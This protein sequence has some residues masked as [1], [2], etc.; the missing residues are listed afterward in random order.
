MSKTL[1]KNIGR[2][3]TPVGSYSHRGNKQGENLRIDNTWIL[4]EDDIIKAIGKDNVIP[5]DIGEIDKEIDAIDSLVTPG[6]VDGHTHL[7]FHGFRQNEIV[8]KLKGASYLEILKAGGGILDTVKNTRKASFDDLYKQADEAVTEILYSGVTTMEAK[9]GYGLDFDSEIK[10]LEVIN[11]LDETT[12]M[13]LVPTFMGAHA[14][15]PEYKG[16]ADAFIEMLC[17]ELMPY[18]KERKL[19][20]FC[21]IF[22]EDS[23]FNAEQ[24]KKYLEKAKSLGFGLRIHADEIKAIGG[25]KLAGEM[26]TSSAEHLIS[27]N[28]EGL[29]SM[30]KGGTTAMCLPG[31]SFYLGAKYAPVREMIKREI[32]VA[33]AT[34][35]NPGSCP[36]FSLQFVMTLGYLKY[37][38]TPEEILTAVTINPACALG[39]G[40]EVGTIEVGKKADLVIWDAKDVEMLC[41][42]FGTDLAMTV[43]KGGKEIE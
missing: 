43:I 19:A 24:S 27:I 42:R 28:E 36:S 20:K 9:S 40:E 1:I 30:K 21:D 5:D 26:K 29:E 34:D 35:Y 3:Q 25:S 23:V 37:R 41:Y 15:P 11:A 33:I 31:T 6:F 32:P 17:E 38:M 13:T 39:L 10:M 2:L 12:D 14:I 18:I 7:I 22:C 16:R 4:I 8:M